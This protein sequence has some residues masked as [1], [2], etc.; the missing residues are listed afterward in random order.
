MIVWRWESFDDCACDKWWWMKTD[1][2]FLLMLR[3]STGRNMDAGSRNWMRRSSQQKQ[4]RDNVASGYS[5]AVLRCPMPTCTH[6]VVLV[7][8]LRLWC[9]CSSVLLFVV[10]VWMTMS[11]VSCSMHALINHNRQVADPYFRCGVPFSGVEI[12]VVA[13]STS[14]WLGGRGRKALTGSMSSCML[15]RQRRMAFTV[16]PT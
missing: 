14:L 5:C 15:L 11:P 2:F 3:V 9:L 1:C 13:Q 7:L 8:C 4:A 10:F 16:C 12:C 6:T